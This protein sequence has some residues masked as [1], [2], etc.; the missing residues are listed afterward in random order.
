MKFGIG[1]T[2]N[3]YKITQERLKSKYFPKPNKIYLNV[4][5]KI[6]LP[7]NGKLKYLL[8][9][10]GRGITNLYPSSPCR[11]FSKIVVYEKIF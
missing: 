3:V 1:D 11:K 7:R 6:Y 2:F 4:P 5:N 9:Y 8:L 10:I